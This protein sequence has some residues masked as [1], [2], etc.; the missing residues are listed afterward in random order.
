MPVFLE[1][2]H[3]KEQGSV[4]LFGNLKESYYDNSIIPKAPSK[5]RGLS[6]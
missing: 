6:V 5:E 4:A 1:D 3:N 2:F